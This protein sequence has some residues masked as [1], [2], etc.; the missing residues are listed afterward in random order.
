MV[1]SVIAAENGVSWIDSTVTGM[2][3]GPGNVKTEYSV[4]EF[5]YIKNDY[6]RLS[7]LLDV[8][9]KFFEPLKNEYMWGD[10]TYYYI[11]AN[12]SV[13]P[14]YVQEIID[15]KNYN[16]NEDSFHKSI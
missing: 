1:N 5:K 14:T 7:R 10:N 6:E 11:S 13:H 3:R 8:I 9:N 4:I 16:T 12:K 15:N 2:G